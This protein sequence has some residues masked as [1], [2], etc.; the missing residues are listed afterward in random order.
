MFVD[1]IFAAFLS[2]GSRFHILALGCFV[3]CVVTRP[4]T[5]RIHL[6]PNQSSDGN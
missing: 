4:M 2:E 3:F 5:V 6:D 1:L